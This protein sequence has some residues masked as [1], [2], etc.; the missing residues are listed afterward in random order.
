MAA[1]AAALVACLTCPAG[2]AP[3]DLDALFEGVDEFSAPGV[4]AAPVA[5]FGPDAFVVATASLGKERVSVIAAARCGEGRVLTMGHEGMLVTYIDQPNT[6][7]FMLN[8]ARWASQKEQ[9]RVG[10]VSY[11]KL[12]DHLTASGLD[13]AV[14]NDADLDG[15]LGGHDVIVASA[16]AL[17]TPPNAARVENLRAFIEKGGGLL[18]GACAWGWEQLNPGGDL[19]TEFGGTALLAPMGLAWE[20]ATVGLTTGTGFADDR[21]SL[22]LT[23]A[24][25]A[26]KALAGHEAGDA[27]LTDEDLAQVGVVLLSALRAV[28]DDDE[29][30]MPEFNRLVEAGGTDVYPTPDAPVTR[31]DPLARIVTTR[32]LEQ[33]LATPVDEVSKHPAG[34]AFP[35]AVPDDAERIATTIAIDAGLPGWIDGA[36]GLTLPGI[37]SRG[38]AAWHSTGLYAPAGERITITV[39]AGMADA[40]LAVR[41]GC[42]ADHIWG[43]PDWKRFPVVSR[44]FEVSEPTTIAANAFGG[45][46]YIETPGG[47]LTPFDVEIAGGT[48]SPRFILGETPVADWRDRIRHLPAPWGEIAGKSLVISLPSETLRTLDDPESLMAFWDL[49]MDADSDLIGAPRERVRPERFVCDVQISVGY[50]HAG[51]PLMTYLDMPEVITNK[52]RVI[53]KDHGGVWGLFHEVGHNHQLGHWTFGGTGEVT[54]NLFTLYAMERACHIPVAENFDLYGEKTQQK[55]ADHIAAGAPFDRWKGDAFL[56]LTMYVQLQQAFGWGAF[57]RVFAGYRDAPA[58]ELPKTD[59]EKRDQWLVRFSQEVGRDLGPF[60]ETWGVPT[61]DEARAKV[62]DL[63]EWIPEG[64][65]G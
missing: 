7:Q 40:K 37:Y 49:V 51:Y 27:E 15:D 65:G 8:A 22:R 17:G 31:A 29:L 2:A 13:V 36:D 10:V 54:V 3:A 41:I 26:L 62:T 18:T 56:A 60:F 20:G 16:Y 59:D 23:H 9:P 44:R 12:A 21:E 53:T 24:G 39:P 42:H 61:S 14:I 4:L 38:A 57:E 52:E 30:L 35:G 55:I 43:R 63:P 28:P 47:G 5:A 50:M 64:L 11:D 58:D 48:P 19:P 34:D 46:I 6:A 33:L 25:D 1:V 45:L 32:T